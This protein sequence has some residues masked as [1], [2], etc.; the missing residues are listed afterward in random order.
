L[1]T[2]SLLFELASLLGGAACYEIS[3]GPLQETVEI[4]TNF[5]CSE[6][7]GDSTRMRGQTANEIH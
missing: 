5:V 2:T 6:T 7:P 1:D 4:I 3:V